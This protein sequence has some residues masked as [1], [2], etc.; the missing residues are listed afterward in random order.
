M[1]KTPEFWVAVSFVLFIGILIWKKVPGLVISALDDR[2]ERIANELAEARKLREEAQQLL[3]DYER[4]RKGAASQAESIVE[5]ARSEAELYAAETRAKLADSIARRTKMAE[6]KIA[7]AEAGAIKD[8][9]AAAS[10]L[11]IDAASDM[12]AAAA[13]GAKGNKLI[14][15]SIDLI[16]T[17]LN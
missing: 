8:V 5:Q 10:E 9:R 12:I 4:K 3:A 16:K 15:E 7:R 2:A 14:D 13:K 17:R 6:D 1:L 11:A